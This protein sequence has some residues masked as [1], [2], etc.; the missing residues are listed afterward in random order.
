MT[1]TD[2]GFRLPAGAWRRLTVVDRWDTIGEIRTL[3]SDAIASGAIECGRTD[4]D[5]SWRS[6]R[7]AGVRFHLPD[8]AGT[9]FRHGSDPVVAAHELLRLLDESTDVDQGWQKR[10]DDRRNAMASLLLGFVPGLPARIDVRMSAVDVTHDID[11]LPSI[12]VWD[13]RRSTWRATPVPVEGRIAAARLHGHC[14]YFEKRSG[15]WIMKQHHFDPEF[16]ASTVGII[17][18]L[19]AIEGNPR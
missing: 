4:P 1:T 9:V 15:Q 14:V 5:R 3:V 7:L 16:A 10:V 8:I 11:G 6:I 19:R 12:S 2:A 17:E 18:A 13:D